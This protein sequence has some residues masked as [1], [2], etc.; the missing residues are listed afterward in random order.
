[1]MIVTL[2]SALVVDVWLTTVFVA[3]AAVAAAPVAAPAA[4][5]APALPALIDP[6]DI[7]VF[8]EMWFAG[9]LTPRLG[10]NLLRLSAW[11]GGSVALF[12]MRF[13]GFR[14]VKCCAARRF[15]EQNHVFTFRKRAHTPGK[16]AGA[17]PAFSPAC[18]NLTGAD[19]VDFNRA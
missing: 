19:D 10:K 3:V 12:L 7:C 18:R 8:L 15:L 13:T 16:G 4:L 2:P 1:M 6:I 5:V 9:S 14:R 17:Q 11:N